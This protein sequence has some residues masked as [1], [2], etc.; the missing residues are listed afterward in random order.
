MTNLLRAEVR[1]LLT[2]RATYG[3]VA[4]LVGVTVVA[5]GQ[6]SGAPGESG[7][8]LW[9]RQAFFLAT[10]QAQIFLSALGVKM[11]TDEFR[12]GTIVPSLLVTPR[13]GRLVTAKI[14]TAA[15]AG[16]VASLLAALALTAAI[17]PSL[18]HAL[19]ATEL[20]SLSG[21]VVAG[22]LWT[23]LAAGIGWVVRH[24][25]GAIVGVIVWFV[26]VEQMAGSIV[27]RAA[28]WLPGALGSTV[29]AAQ[30]PRVIAAAALILVA[31]VVGGGLAATA[32]M[33]RRD[34][35]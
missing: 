22:T 30:N 5:V 28:D 34:V 21:L 26:A 1:K 9:E 3:I 35:A 24:Q 33:R 25:V 16:F 17:L 13:R 20:R 19:T 32:V 10:F 23:A 29:G 6:T 12:Y 14:L 11:A 18:G 7:R 31:Y 27:K 15:A 4:A 8:M 2:T